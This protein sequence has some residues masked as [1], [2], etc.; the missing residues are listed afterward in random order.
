MRDP[1][2]PDNADSNH[3]AFPLPVSPVIDMVEL[4]VIRIEMLPT[5]ADHHAAPPRPW[6][7]A[8]PN[9]Y[10]SEHQNLRTD[11]KPLHVVQPEGASFRVTQV[12]E[13]GRIID[14]QKWSFRVGF[15]QRESMVL[16]D[17]DSPF[18]TQP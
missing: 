4:R 17:V 15:N 1:A 7:I 14:W 16:Y 10:T 5:G 3:Y 8:P 9:E 12:G 11:L 2:V 6:K 18:S 13:T